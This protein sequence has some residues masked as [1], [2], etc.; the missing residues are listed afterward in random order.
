MNFSG[1]TSRTLGPVMMGP[2]SNFRY[3]GCAV[4]EVPF[5]NLRALHQKV[6]VFYTVDVLPIGAKVISS[7]LS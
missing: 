2:V 4:S 1:G 7:Q 3:G 5:G 6:H